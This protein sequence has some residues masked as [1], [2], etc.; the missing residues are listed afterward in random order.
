MNTHTPDTALRRE[1]DDEAFD[2][3]MDAFWEAPGT[4]LDGVRA[5]ILEYLNVTGR[6]AERAD[7]ERAMA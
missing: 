1:L 4:N 2:A 3:A 5:A 6:A 7:S